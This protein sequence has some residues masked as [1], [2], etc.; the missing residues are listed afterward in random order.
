MHTAG[1]HLTGAAVPKEIPPTQAEALFGA[2]VDYVRKNGDAFDQRPFLSLRYIGRIATISAGVAAAVAPIEHGSSIGGSATVVVAVMAFTAQLGLGIKPDHNNLEHARK[3]W[4]GK[5]SG[6]QNDAL[7]ELFSVRKKGG[8]GQEVAMRW[9]GPQ[10]DEDYSGRDE[11]LRIAALAEKCGVS[12]L[13]VGELLAKECG[14]DRL[15]GRQYTMAQWLWRR[16]RLPVKGAPRKDVVREAAPK[17]WLAYA[18]DSSA[19]EIKE[20]EA[21]VALEHA[22]LDGVTAYMGFSQRVQSLVIR[23]GRSVPRE[24]LKSS[25]PLTAQQA[26]A[27]RKG[28]QKDPQRPARDARGYIAAAVAGI[29]VGL[30]G[31]GGGQYAADEM[32]QNR[33]QEAAAEIARQHGVDPDLAD[34]SPEA[35]DKMVHGW[36]R[37]NGPW[38]A[39]Y[40]GRTDV[41]KRLQKIGDDAPKVAGDG[42]TLAAHHATLS[43]KDDDRTTPIW[44]LSTHNLPDDVLKGNWSQA[45][46]HRFVHTKKA[47]EVPAIEWKANTEVYGKD[48][49]WRS[50]RAGAEPNPNYYKGWVKV[51]ADGSKVDLPTVNVKVEVFEDVSKDGRADI[52]AVP[53][54]DGMRVIAANQDGTALSWIVKPDGTTSLIFGGKNPYTDGKITYYIAQ[55]EMPAYYGPRA[56]EGITL[57]HDVDGDPM[58]VSSEVSSFEALR[59]VLLKKMPELDGMT[60]AQTANYLHS[61]LG[62]K[63]PPFS[64]KQL[65]KFDSVDD[66]VAA[67]LA[68]KRTDCGYAATTHIL[69]NK[70]GGGKDLNALMGYLNTKEPHTLDVSEWHLR[71]VSKGAVDKDGAVWPGI[72][73]DATPARGLE[74]MTAVAQKSEQGRLPVAPFGLVGAVSIAAAGAYL[75]RRKYNRTVTRLNERWESR[76]AADR[77]T[78]MA[79]LRSQPAVELRRAEAVVGARHW[80]PAGTTLTRADMTRQIIRDPGNKER[81]IQALTAAGAYP[82]TPP[83]VAGDPVTTKAVRGIAAMARKAESLPPRKKVPFTQT[84]KSWAARMRLSLARTPKE[85]LQDSLDLA[86][87]WGKQESD[88]RFIDDKNKPTAVMPQKPTPL[89]EA[90]WGKP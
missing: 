43:V 32:L 3:V 44:T 57:S 85:V 35:V 78:A 84:V 40:K 70:V 19:Y 31:V 69:V 53:V 60:T 36:S 2:H 42:R 74:P 5:G 80:A 50:E 86:A 71:S 55:P 46:S 29:V 59:T 88:D 72:I 49:S 75:G 34:V 63:T 76:V 23:E 51:E 67:V 26:I 73:Y 47:G 20:G 82:R 12:K 6:E 65:K 54:P 37:I 41:H 89:E 14:D 68:A 83:T 39:Y 33:K 87:I 66:I 90:T 77:D 7:Y 4:D 11:L 81:S 48:G 1:E 13:V 22:G 17:Q 52:M 27:L 58:E 25:K 64:E 38:D 10:G 21:H 9:Y 28:E 61:K 30:G 8:I 79:A 16:K 24:P 62:Y 45:T 15:P 56:T 18:A